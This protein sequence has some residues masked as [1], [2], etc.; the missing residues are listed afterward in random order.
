M[1]ATCAICGKTS[2]M[3]TTRKLLRGHYNPTGKVRK[4]PNLQWYRLPTKGRIKVCAKCLK[5][6]TR[7]KLQEKLRAVV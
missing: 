2:Y 6:L 7:G 4:Y 5:A 1:A 3:A